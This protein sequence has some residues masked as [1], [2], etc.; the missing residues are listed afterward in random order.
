MSEII[1]NHLELLENRIEELTTVNRFESN[2]QEHCETE[3][4]IDGLKYSASK[5]KSARGGFPVVEKNNPAVAAIAYALEN[6]E[7]IEFLRYWNEGDF[8]ICREWNNVP[9]EVFIG[10]DSLFKPEKK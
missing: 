9:D 7:G 1:K 10:A 2:F 3:G 5:L 4:L 8:D 6:D